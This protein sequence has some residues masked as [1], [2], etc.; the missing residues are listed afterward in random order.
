[1]NH[2][3]IDL[4]QLHKNMDDPLN[5]TL[6]IGTLFYKKKLRYIKTQVK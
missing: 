5:I 3:F 6:I 2:L 4:I 1:M